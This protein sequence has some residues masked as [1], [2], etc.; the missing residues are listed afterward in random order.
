MRQYSILMRHSAFSVPSS[1][2]QTR[3]LEWPCPRNATARQRGRAGM[4]RPT[5]PYS[6]GAMGAVPMACRIE[7]KGTAMRRHFKDMF[8]ET[9]RRYGFAV[10]VVTLALI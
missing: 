4:A 6:P 3:L 10:V 7:E 1:W 8:T 9:S 2:R 5:N